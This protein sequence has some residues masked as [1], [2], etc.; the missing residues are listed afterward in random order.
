MD[1]WLVKDGA[2][3]VRLGEV[4]DD[5]GVDEAGRD[6]S[7]AEVVRDGS[8]TATVVRCRRQGVDDVDCGG[9]DVVVDDAAGRADARAVETWTP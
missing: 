1:R 2:V 6:A 3:R 4:V 8:M 5:R 7:E 9:V